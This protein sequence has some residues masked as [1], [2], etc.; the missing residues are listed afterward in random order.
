MKKYR[1]MKKV[2]VAGLQLKKKVKSNRSRTKF[3]GLI[4]LLATIALPVAVAILPMLTGAAVSL[5]IV[6]FW[7]AFKSVSFKTNEGLTEFV[8]ATLYGL[9]LLG[10]IL[11][12]FRSLGKLKDLHKKKGTKTDGFNHSG[13]AMNAMAKI[14]SGSFLVTLVT[15][16]LI[17]LLC[18]DAKVEGYW[19]VIVLGAGILVHLFAGVV[20]G[21]ISYFDFEGDQLVE[22]KREVGRFAPFFRN[23]LQLAAVF[24]IMFFLLRANAKSALISQF[25]SRDVAD[26]FKGDIKTLIVALLQAAA[27][28]CVFVL[29]KHATGISEYS[30]DGAH[31]A[32][33]K[34][35]RVFSFFLFLLAGATVACKYFL[36]KETKLDVN[37]IIVAAIALVMFV[38]ELLMRKMP[39]L[40]GQVAKKEKES[41]IY[42]DEAMANYNET[43]AMQ[44]DE[45]FVM[46]DQQANRP[47]YPPM[48]PMP[49]MPPMPVQQA[50]GA[51]AGKGTQYIPYVIQ[52][53]YPV[54]M[55]PVQQAP[56][57]QSAPSVHILP[58]LN[59]KGDEVKQLP[60]PTTEE[61]EEEVEQVVQKV[62]GPRVEVDCPFCKRKLRVNS[63]A[64][65]HRCPICDRVFALRG[66]SGK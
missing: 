30:I 37:V 38:V 40:P 17:N 34:T 45:E 18:K 31:G 1:K 19:L 25:V 3:V 33:M 42:L 23:F 66:K 46:N 36:L 50:N 11:N 48:M 8:V 65:H 16:F 28:L 4:L 60:A 57:Q 54:M 20:G 5:K 44:G 47:A 59:L 58:V 2:T 63:G 39:R 24:G 56:A 27:V 15:Y 9:M 64:Q 43:A 26:L 22:Q 62:D 7:K 49:P 32:G 53:F 35:Y 13:Y 21:K 29:A 14:F 51:Q 52:T 6:D 55:P 41:N 61:E 10:L 12:V